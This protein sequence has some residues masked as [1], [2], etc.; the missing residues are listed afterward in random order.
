MNRYIKVATILIAAIVL[1]V[2]AAIV[3][4]PAQEKTPL[5]TTASEAIEA[6][7]AY[8]SYKLPATETKDKLAYLYT[9]LERLETETTD[10][11][12]KEAITMVELYIWNIKARLGFHGSVTSGAVDEAVQGIK[13]AISK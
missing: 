7:E 11:K 1:A 4:R 2:M 8:K 6:L 9:Q 3:T 13:R 12:D 5:E 10:A